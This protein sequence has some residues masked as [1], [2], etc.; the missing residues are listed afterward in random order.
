MVIQKALYKKDDEIIEVS[1]DDFKSQESQMRYKGNLFCPTSG[2]AS[3]LIYVNRTLKPGYFKTFPRENHSSNCDFR[4][5]RIFGRTGVNTE[6]VINVELSK[7]RKSRAL[8]EAYQLSQLTPTQIEERKNR[9]KNA[10]KK[11]PITER[12]KEMVGVN[13]V[14]NTDEENE[15]E[16]SIRGNNIL[17]RTIETLQESDVTKHRLLIGIV[18]SVSYG[19]ENASLTLKEGSK[20]LQVKFEEA[21][22]ANSPAYSGY[23]HFVDRLIEENENVVFSGIGQVRKSSDSL[24]ELVIYNGED[25]TLNGSSLLTIAINTA[26]QNEQ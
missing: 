17:K 18:E 26:I 24:K 2:C 8:K 11:R 3:K 10:Q 22:F 25:F 15:S 12:K 21:F 9:G 13:M 5:D 14:T 19:K 7:E 23:F 4:F 16:N 20:S 6:N 1:I